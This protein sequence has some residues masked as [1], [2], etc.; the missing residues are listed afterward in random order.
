MPGRSFGKPTVD[1]GRVP[2]RGHVMSWSERSVAENA[3]WAARVVLIGL[4]GISCSCS[5]PGTRS[6]AVRRRSLT[7]RT[8]L[9]AVSPNG[10]A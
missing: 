1:G 4:L 10:C 5:P 2:L 7:L 3:A 9:W 8:R 6:P